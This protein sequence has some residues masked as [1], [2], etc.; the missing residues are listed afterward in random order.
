MIFI[1]FYRIEIQYRHLLT[2]WKNRQWHVKQALT[3][4]EV[5]TK[6][7]VLKT[8]N[9]KQVIIVIITTINPE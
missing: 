4:S 3:S 2:L 9:P 6:L 5:L 8:T 7:Q 1:S